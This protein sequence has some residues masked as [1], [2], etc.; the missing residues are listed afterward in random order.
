MSLAGV[1]AEMIEYWDAEGGFADLS[2]LQGL[3]NAASVRSAFKERC[4]LIVFFKWQPI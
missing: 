2:Q 4:R 1:M 3:L